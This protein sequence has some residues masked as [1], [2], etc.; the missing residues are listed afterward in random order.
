MKNLFK[1][2]LIVIICGFSNSAFAQKAIRHP[3]LNQTYSKGKIYI[4]GQYPPVKALKITLLNDSILSFINKE[5]GTQQSINVY[6]TSVNRLKL[7]TGT[8][9]GEYAIYGGI[10]FG[11]TY[12]YEVISLG[13][14]L[15]GDFDFL[16]TNNLGDWL[17]LVK[18]TAIATAGGALAGALLGVLI[19]DYK[20]F[21]I[22]DNST[23]FNL[24]L[25]PYYCN[26]GGVGMAVRV[27][28]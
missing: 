13:Y 23:T 19:P 1:L 3:E 24:S 20:N 2:V 25:S 8:K 26:D 27:V 21:Y 15:T 7:K 12:L 9:A 4:Q 6:T 11:L 17:P 28:F 10:T 14:A 18:T 5:T 22:K 16:K